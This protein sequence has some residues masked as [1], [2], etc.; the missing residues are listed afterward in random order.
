MHRFAK[1]D[2][3]PKYLDVAP[4]LMNLDL[5][6]I[7]MSNEYM[8]KSKERGEMFDIKYSPSLEV[9]TRGREERSCV[10]VCVSI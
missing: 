2:Y 8:T 1:P 4:V 7:F 9:R 6:D 10:L 5:V 3:G